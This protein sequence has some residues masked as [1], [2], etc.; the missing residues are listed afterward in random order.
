MEIKY[1]I[2]FSFWTAFASLLFLGAIIL[3]YFIG[4]I[5]LRYRYQLQ[6]NTQRNINKEIDLGIDL[7]A[8]RETLVTPIH[9]PT[10]VPASSST[11]SIQTVCDS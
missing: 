4:S 3:I 5:F 10:P 6:E 9:K 8:T 2:T 7:E 1:L 11:L